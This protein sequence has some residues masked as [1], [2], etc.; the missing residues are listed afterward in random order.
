MM[1][2]EK[3]NESNYVIRPSH[4]IEHLL[5]LMRKVYV[6][7]MFHFSNKKRYKKKIQLYKFFSSI[8]IQERRY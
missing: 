8:G 3:K 1:K 4:P 6:I 2:Y 7:L 5:L